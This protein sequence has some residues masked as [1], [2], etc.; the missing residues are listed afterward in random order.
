MDNIG[1]PLSITFVYGHPYHT[2]KDPMW[3]KLRELKLLSRPNWLCIGDFNQILSVND[4]LSFASYK[5]TGMDAF[6]TACF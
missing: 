1:N 6:Y 3:A 2:K 4:K 5:T